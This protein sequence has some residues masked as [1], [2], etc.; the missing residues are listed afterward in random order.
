MVT[1]L[2]ITMNIDGHIN[3]CATAIGIKDEQCAAPT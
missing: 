2:W 3:R 1:E